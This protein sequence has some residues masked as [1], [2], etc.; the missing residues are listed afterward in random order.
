MKKVI[1]LIVAVLL[2]VSVQAQDDD[3]I[4]DD[5]SNQPDISGLVEAPSNAIVVATEQCRLWAQ[6]DAIEAAEL[7]EYLLSC[8]NEELESQGYQ[9]VTAL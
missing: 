7:D 2:S 5:H 1:S 6:D 3:A 4:N 8:V 9:S